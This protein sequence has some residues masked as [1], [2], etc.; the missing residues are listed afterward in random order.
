[1]KLSQYLPSCYLLSSDVHFVCPHTHTHNTNSAHFPT[2]TALHSWHALH[3]T[4]KY[5]RSRLKARNEQHSHHN[6]SHNVRHCCS[7]SST[8]TTG[9]KGTMHTRLC[10]LDLIYFPT[11][12]GACSSSSS[13]SD[14]TATEPPSIPFR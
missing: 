7:S 6:P 5:F 2:T 9:S 12:D 14:R 11:A 1:M 13:S 10:Y 3:T 8:T 4:N